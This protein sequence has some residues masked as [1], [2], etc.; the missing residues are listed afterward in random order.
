MYPIVRF[1]NY[2]SIFLFMFLLF[3]TYYQFGVN[4]KINEIG[5]TTTKQNVFFGAALV[6]IF[7]NS[8]IRVIKSQ[9]ISMPFSKIKL[10]NK[11]MWIAD[12]ESKEALIKVFKTWFESYCVIFNSVLCYCLFVLM[13]VNIMSTG[14]FST[15][16]FVLYVGLFFIGTWWSVLLYRL[17]V[18]KLYL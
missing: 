1:V 13:M 6:F 4:V 9:T 8:L 7:F 10:P 3:F 15:Y 18:K 14:N 12:L 11:Q 17:S 16:A 2:I 5:E